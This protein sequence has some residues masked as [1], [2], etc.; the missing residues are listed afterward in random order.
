[1]TILPP[2]IGTFP[3]TPAAGGTDGHAAMSIHAQAAGAS[4]SS[5]LDAP[6]ASAKRR[7][8]AR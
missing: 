1:M 8:G 3:D 5:P 4:Q 7:L 2:L 6:A